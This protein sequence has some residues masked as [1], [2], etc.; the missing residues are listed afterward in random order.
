MA[1]LPWFK[2]YPND[3]MGDMN[4]RRCSNEAVGVYMKFLCLAFDSEERGVVITSG[5]AWTDREIVSAIGGPFDDTL[6]AF[7]ELI[8][9]NLIKIR[10]DG[11]YFNS[12][13]VR[14]EAE[15]NKTR[16]RVKKHR[17][18]NKS[19]P[20]DD[21]HPPN[22][23]NVTGDVTQHVTP[24]VTEMKQGEVRGQKSEVRSQK[25]KTTTTSEKNRASAQKQEE[26]SINSPPL[27]AQ[28]ED[29]PPDCAAPPPDRSW[30]NH[31]GRKMSNEQ[32]AKEVM[33]N[34]IALEAMMM[35]TGL[36]HKATVQIW[37][38]AFN[39]H[40]ASQHQHV[41]NIKSYSSHFNNWLMKKTPDIKADPGVTIERILRGSSASEKPLTHWEK[42]EKKRMEK[43]AQLQKKRYRF[44][45]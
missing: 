24:D 39:A 37:L 33:S 43:A 15:R 22:Q 2:F 40:R 8:K 3:F 20:P 17:E 14:D 34:E 44:N 29:P 42:H 32:L 41:D 38:L 9:W 5:V 4:L 23:N 35:R 11:A 1:E 19:S 6:R 16:E 45:E 30:K 7:H 12:R 25:K 31:P 13:M 10:K 27:N 28:R 26:N 21:T 36:K 18:K